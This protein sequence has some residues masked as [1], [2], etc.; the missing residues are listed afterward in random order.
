MRGI[1]EKV[2]LIF[3][4]SAMSGGDMTFDELAETLPNGFHDTEVSI[5]T[6][7]YVRRELLLRMNVWVGMLGTPSC[8]TY[9]MAIVRLVGLQFCVIETPD[10][11]YSYAEPETL[12]IDIGSID[13]LKD[14]T[15]TKLPQGSTSGA[16]TNWIFVQQWNSRL[17]VSAVGAELDWA[18]EPKARDLR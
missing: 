6:I 16:F 1:I 11:N 10:P 2:V 7:D 3:W 9:R 17:F 18:G 14:R 12:T 13:S 15:E 4:P 8:E 5:V